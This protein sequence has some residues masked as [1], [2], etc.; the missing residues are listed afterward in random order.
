MIRKAPKDAVVIQHPKSGHVFALVFPPTKKGILHAKAEA[1]QFLYNQELQ[2]LGFNENDV[3]E[4]YDAIDD[5]ETNLEDK[6]F[7]KFA[8]L[9]RFTFPQPEDF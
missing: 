1:I 2:D 5:V 9:L 4:L 3:E 8:N 6:T 7:C